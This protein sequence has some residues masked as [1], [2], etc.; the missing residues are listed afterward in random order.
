MNKLIS[1]TSIVLLVLTCTMSCKKNN[2]VVDQDVVPPAYAKFNVRIAE[3]TAA[4]YYISGAGTPFKIPIGITTVSNKD[5]TIQFCYTSATAT[6]GVQYN[7]PTSIVIP[8]GKVLDSISIQGL[9]AGYPQ[10]SR[11]DVLYIKICGGDVPVSD[12]WNTFKLTIRKYC[13]VILANL[14]GS[15][16]ATEYLSNGSYNYGPYPSGVVNLTTTGAT[17]ASGKFV[18]LFD[19][20]WSNINF[21][22][23]WS[24]PANFKINIPLQATGASNAA[25]NYSYVRSTDGKIN[26]FSSCEETFSISLDLML[27]PTIVDYSGYQI[28]LRR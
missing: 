4:T 12:Y 18:N 28:K 17:T 23:D 6:A 21:T 10:S 24:D 8:A 13:D 25:G 14:G 26:T 16:N 15:F 27:S 5:R 20:G 3:D 9:L 2:L 22:M 19:Y 7:A 11:I 1:S